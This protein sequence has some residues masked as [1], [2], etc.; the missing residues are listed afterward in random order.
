[1]QSNN[2]FLINNQKNYNIYKPDS[3]IFL[4]KDRLPFIW[5]AAR[6]TP[7]SANPR[8]TNEP[9][10]CPSIWHFS[11]QGLP[12]PIVT[13]TCRS[14][15]HYIFTLTPAK[16]G[17]VIFC[18]TICQK[19][20]AYPLGSVSLYAVRTFLYRLYGSGNPIL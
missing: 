5:S 7:L 19:T 6:A 17:A 1:M 9:F 13:N 8:T 16:A 18:G 2:P 20:F 10:L 14:L 3:V 4:T 15:L 11:T 12:A